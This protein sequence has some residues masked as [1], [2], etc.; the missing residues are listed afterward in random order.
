M[1]ALLKEAGHDVTL[2]QL[3]EELA[4]LPSQQ[5]YIDHIEKEAPDLI[6]FSVV[7]NQWGYTRKLARWSRKATNVPLICGGMGTRK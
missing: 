7:T 1:S 6:G 3:C 5:E 2:L 4:P